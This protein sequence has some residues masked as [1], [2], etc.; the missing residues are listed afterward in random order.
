MMGILTSA[1]SILLAILGDTIPKLLY[2]EKPV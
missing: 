1:W 2:L